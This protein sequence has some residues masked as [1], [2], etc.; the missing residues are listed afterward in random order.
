MLALLLV[1]VGEGKR[2]AGIVASGSA[3]VNLG[4]AVVDTVLLLHRA[5]SRPNSATLTAAPYRQH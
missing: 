5:F 3:V 4:N 1:I 2:E